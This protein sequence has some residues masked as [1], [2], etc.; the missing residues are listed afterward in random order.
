M[1]KPFENLFARRVAWALLKPVRTYIVHSPLNRGKGFL[2]RKLIE[3]VLPGNDA[4]FLHSTKTG[5]IIRLQYRETLG[6]S[7]LMQGGFE[8]VERAVVGALA[9]PGT[10]AFDVGANIG[11]F[12][13]SLARGVGTTGS[14]IAV[15]PVQSTAKRIEENALLNAIGNIHIEVCAAGNRDG[16]VEVAETTDS[17]YNS[18]IGINHPGI[19]QRTKT[20]VAMKKIDDLWENAGRPNVS[21]MKIDVEGAEM[22]VLQGAVNLIRTCRPHL[23]L[24]A[25]TTDD[26]DRLAGFIANFGYSGSQPEGFMPWNYLFRA[27]VKQGSSE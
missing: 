27:A 4:T 22:D 8:D 17:A 21:V 18:T 11:M 3:P 14:V 26:R 9:L 10:T 24:E 20:R 2:L 6:R 12:T 23:M 13:I 19:K 16:F 7:V 5:D 25:N 15:E 1:E